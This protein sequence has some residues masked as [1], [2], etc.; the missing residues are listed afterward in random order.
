MPRASITSGWLDL[1]AVRQA[2]RTGVQRR[3]VGDA[4]HVIGV[5]RRAFDKAGAQLVEA[6]VVQTEDAGDLGQKVVFAG[7][8]LAIG[9]G[10]VEQP[11]HQVDQHVAVVGAEHGADLGGIGVKAR[12][13]LTGEVEDTGGVLLPRPRG[14]QRPGGRRPPRRV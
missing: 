11:L 5:A 10:D 1:T 3:V 4:Q 2:A 12:H 7:V 8:I 13:I 9:K 6:A 14:W